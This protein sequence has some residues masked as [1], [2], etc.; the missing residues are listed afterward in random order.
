MSKSIRIRTT[1]NGDDKYIKVELK[2]DFDLLEILSLKIKQSDVYA[3]F[4][5]SYGV[6]AGRVII[7]NG[8]GVPNVKVSI[9]IPKEG[10]NKILEQLYPYNS[11]TPDE[12]NVNGIRYNLLPDTQ[13]TLDHTP[14][15]TFPNKQ[16]ILDD[17]VSLEIYEKYYKYTTT[18]NEAGDFI[19]FGVPTGNQILHYD[20]DISDIGFISTRPYELIEQGYSKE[21]FES[22]FKFKSSRNLD[23][24]TQIISQNI[25]VL[26]QP[27]WC[28]D[29][30]AGR[31]IGITRQDISVD[32]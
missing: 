17:R 27:F 24:L 2:Q 14:V 13:Q 23:S 21:L 7:N 9:F 30:S 6:V 25:P 32:S 28:D 11:P 5:S 12:K 4:C 26:V 19:L 3:N 15:G 8:F 31:V 18:T 29:L 10:N 20:M 22:P 1:P 16:S